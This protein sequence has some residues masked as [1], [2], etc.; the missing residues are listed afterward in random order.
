[1]TVS[2]AMGVGAAGGTIQVFPCFRPTNA[3][4][5]TAATVVGFATSSVTS[6]PSSRQMYSVN[7][8]YRPGVWSV[9]SNQTIWIGMCTTGAAANVNWDPQVVGFITTLIF[10]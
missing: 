7:Y 3:A 6:P 2:N 8:V 10:Q 4:A 1:M 5:G 9:P